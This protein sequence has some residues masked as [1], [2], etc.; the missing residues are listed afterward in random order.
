MSGSTATKEYNRS[1]TKSVVFDGKAADWSHWSDKFLSV[2]Y[3]N[4]YEGVLL[5]DEKPVPATQVTKTK[6]EERVFKA[7]KEA[8]AN[9]VLSCSGTAY[10]AV[11]SAKT[12]DHPRGDAGVTWKNLCD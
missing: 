11:S 6:E 3:V 12:K 10:G 9:L 8:Y 7:N 4:G 2:A 5:G 1:L